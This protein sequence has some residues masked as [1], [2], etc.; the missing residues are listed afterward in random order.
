MKLAPKTPLVGREVETGLVE[1]DLSFS[2]LAPRSSC[3][4]RL[5][6][7]TLPRRDFTE[8]ISILDQSSEKRIFFTIVTNIF[9]FGFN[10]WTL[11]ITKASFEAF[12]Q[13]NRMLVHMILKE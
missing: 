8:T 9:I 4:D 10:F 13:K 3:S 7:T 2:P 11:A 5:V 6:F 12:Y 1:T